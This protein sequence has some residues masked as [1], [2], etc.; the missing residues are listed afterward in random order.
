MSRL[1]RRPLLGLG[2]IAAFAAPSLARAATLTGAALA[3]SGNRARLTLTVEGTQ[4]WS[5]SAHDDPR[6]LIIELPGAAWRGAA[7]LRGAGLV[8]SGR[9]VAADDVLVLELAGPALPSPGPDR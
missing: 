8:R 7:T 6:R 3:A 5:V 4:R 1:G 2:L 9:F